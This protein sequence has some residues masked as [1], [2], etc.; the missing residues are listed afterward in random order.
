MPDNDSNVKPKLEKSEIDG[1]T[2]ALTSPSPKNT[3]TFVFGL[4]PVPINAISLA[5]I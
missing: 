1:V 5:L 2:K 4:N 3:Y